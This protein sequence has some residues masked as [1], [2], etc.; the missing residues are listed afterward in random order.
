MQESINTCSYQR[1]YPRHWWEWTSGHP[2]RCPL[3]SNRPQGWFIC[4]L[5]QRGTP[6]GEWC[7]KGG[8]VRW[9]CRRRSC[10]G[11]RGTRRVRRRRW[12]CLVRERCKQSPW[13]G[14]IQGLRDGISWGHGWDVVQFRYR[15]N[16]W[17]DARMSDIIPYTG[18]QRLA[19]MRQDV[20]DRSW[21]IWRTQG[22]DH[23]TCYRG[24]WGSRDW[25]HAIK[26]PAS[27]GSRDPHSNWWIWRWTLNHSGCFTCRRRLWNLRWC[28][29]KQ[30]SLC[31]SW[32]FHY[33]RRPT[34]ISCP[35]RCLPRRGWSHRGNSWMGTF[36][37]NL[38]G[39]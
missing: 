32:R 35:S 5:C 9:C 8:G 39:C 6:M 24:W 30:L 4:R 38:G 21:K 28:F 22:C 10:C 19:N 16:A 13:G 11:Y 20:A 31:R 37:C 34:R 29:R 17:S 1:R 33:T 18:T 2:S 23:R 26:W 7:P 27:T 14:D 12:C 15:A 25:C 3:S 36:G